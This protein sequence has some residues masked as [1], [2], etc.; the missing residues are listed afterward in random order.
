MFFFFVIVISH[1]RVSYI[2]AFV[3]KTCQTA[4]Y[5]NPAVTK[6]S[7]TTSAI[8]TNSGKKFLAKLNLVLFLTTMRAQ[9]CLISCKISV[10]AFEL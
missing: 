9:L 1:V 10:Q 8:I 5:I 7:D 3:V 4:S 2:L 6:I